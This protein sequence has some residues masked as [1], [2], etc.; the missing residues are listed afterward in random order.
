MIISNSLYSLIIIPIKYYIK[1]IYCIDGP[2]SMGFVIDRFN[3]D[4]C[5]TLIGKPKLFFIQACRGQL[6]DSGTLVHD[7][8]TTNSRD[9]GPNRSNTFLIPKYSDLLIFYST[10]PGYYA[11][12]NTHIGSWF[13]QDLC[14]VL[15]HYSQEYD[16]LT[17]ATLVCQKVAFTRQSHTNNYNNKDNRNLKESLNNK[18]QM[19]CF[20]S[21]LTRLV[22]FYH[23]VDNDIKK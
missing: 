10:Y 2:L 4:H 21:T 6:F 11:W 15:Q 17:L 3:T 12:R 23:L 8:P 5:R 13:I 19:P 20:V 18:K 7:S 22:K 9:D 16:L 14:Y 1:V